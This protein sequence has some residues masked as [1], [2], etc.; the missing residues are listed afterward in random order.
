MST[1]IIGGGPRP[2][3]RIVAVS[4]LDGAGTLLNSVTFEIRDGAEVCMSNI[5]KLSYARALLPLVQSG[6]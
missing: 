2:Q 6:E 5:S 3:A 1:V 4:E